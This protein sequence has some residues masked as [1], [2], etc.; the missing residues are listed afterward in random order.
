[1]E[2][3]PTKRKRRRLAWQLWLK[4]DEFDAIVRAAGITGETVGDF[5][6]RAVITRTIAV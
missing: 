6:L 3:Q 5:I 4:G 2:D 1:M